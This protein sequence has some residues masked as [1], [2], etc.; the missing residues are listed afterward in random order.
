MTNP[1]DT[2]TGAPAPAP[3]PCDTCACPRETRAGAMPR[4]NFLIGLSAATGAIA[5]AFLAIPPIAFTIA[6]IARK[7]PPVW[8]P[9]GA[10]DDFEVGRTVSV[11]FE[12][13]GSRQWDGKMARTGAWLRREKPD[14]FIAFSLNCTHLGC[15]VRWEENASLFLCPCHGGVYYKNGVVAG[16]PPPRPLPR[17]NVRIRDGQVEIQ[18]AP[19]PFA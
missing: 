14:E 5:A 3:A 19:I 11:S 10:V 2:A 18:T 17:Y 12:N 4:R 7:H 9:V 16:G 13:A 15:P 1:N 6:S 8:R